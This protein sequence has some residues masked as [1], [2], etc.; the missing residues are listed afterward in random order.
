MESTHILATLAVQSSCRQCMVNQVVTSSSIPARCGAVGGDRN[1]GLPMFAS[2]RVYFATRPPPS[3]PPS[4]PCWP[5]GASQRIDAWHSKPSHARRPAN[6]AGF[7]T[8]PPMNITFDLRPT[9]AERSDPGAT[10]ATG[11]L[12]HLSYLQLVAANQLL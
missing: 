11:A 8:T 7:L 9:S 10:R 5:L 1:Q 6:A 12:L 4:P 2:I 3:H